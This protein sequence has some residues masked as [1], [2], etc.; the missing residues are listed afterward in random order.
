[1]KIDIDRDILA[2]IIDG[3]RFAS[4]MAAPPVESYATIAQELQKHLDRDP[5]FTAGPARYVKGQIAICPVRRGDGFKTRADRLCEHLNGRWS[6][7]EHAYIMSPSKAEKLRLLFN[8]DR[9]A[10][11][12]T[13]ELCPL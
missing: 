10:S 6:N 12:I 7:R 8:A 4:D 3:L 5:G 11:L 2:M 9:D 13:R 1:M